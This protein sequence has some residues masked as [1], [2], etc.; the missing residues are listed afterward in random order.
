MITQDAFTAILAALP[1]PAYPAGSVYTENGNLVTPGEDVFLVVDPISETTRVSWTQ[2]VTTVAR[3]QLTAFATTQ[4]A[5]L[6]RLEAAR[7]ALPLPRYE[8][9][10]LR[11]IGRL[12]QYHVYAQ[13]YLT[14][15]R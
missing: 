5:A 12:G 1:P 15:G 4:S 7:A 2:L 11:R 6:E 3:F 13:D 9:D 14:G 8:P 10:A